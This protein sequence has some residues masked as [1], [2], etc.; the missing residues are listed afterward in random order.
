MSEAGKTSVPFAFLIVEA[1]LE[2]GIFSTL[3]SGRIIAAFTLIDVFGVKLM[4]ILFPVLM[5]SGRF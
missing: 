2:R 4:L 1:L 3:P 5:R